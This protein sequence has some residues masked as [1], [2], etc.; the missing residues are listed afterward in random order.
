[1]SY[2]VILPDAIHPEAL[3][4]ALERG[5]ARCSEPVA[6]VCEIFEDPGVLYGYCESHSAVAVATQRDTDRLD[7]AAEYLAP[8]SY[9]PTADSGHPW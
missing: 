8:A 2:V 7:R 3:S 1:M 5:C 9:G 6:I 4:D